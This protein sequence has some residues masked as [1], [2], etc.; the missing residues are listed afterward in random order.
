MSI[1]S[2]LLSRPIPVESIQLGRLVLDPKYPDHDFI[3]PYFD[4]VSESSSPEPS[5]G[6]T[7]NQETPSFIPDIATQRLQNVSDIVEHARG[8]RLEL[9]LLNL[10]SFAASK[11]PHTTSTSIT[12]I[13]SSLCIIRQLRNTSDY[14][15]AVCKQPLVRDWL[16][17]ESMRFSPNVY[18]ICGFRTLVDARVEQSSNRS[19]DLEMSTA[20][21]ASLIAA[22][23]G[24][25]IIIPTIDMDL[26]AG[27]TT[28]RISKETAKY[29]ANGEQVFAVQYRKVRF[30][31]FSAKRL[32]KA[33]LERGNRWHSLLQSRAGQGIDNA[34]VDVVEA[35]LDETLS[36]AD[37]LG[38]YE[39]FVLDDEEMIVRID[40]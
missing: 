10:L 39:T 16:Q 8:T 34:A 30:S 5:S 40:T 9:N 20:I 31:R 22:A 18:M 12:N 23:A 17:R 37:L 1:N 27:L 38:E 25:P 28:Y 19:A 36:P 7:R 11:F 35:E 26:S 15:T 13:S 33:Y 14:F 4:E 3:Q 24:A 32:D 21:P 29:T 2:L 6:Q